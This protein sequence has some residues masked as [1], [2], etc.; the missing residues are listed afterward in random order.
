MVT[1]LEDLLI[2]YKAITELF[3]NRNYLTKQNK[4]QT[5]VVKLICYDGC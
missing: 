2:V 1:N 4:S 5:N 3:I